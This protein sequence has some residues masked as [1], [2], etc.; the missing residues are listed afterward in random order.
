MVVFVISEEGKP[1]MPTRRFGKVRRLL[2]KGLAKVV[3]HRPFTIQLLYKTTHYTQSVKVGFDTGTTMGFAVVVDN[4]QGGKVVEKGEIRFRRDISK[5]LLQRREYR[6]FRRYRKTPYRKPRFLNRRRPEGWLAPSVRARF[7]HTLRWIERLTKFLPDPEVIV[8]IARFDT[9]NL[10]NPDV[11]GEEYQKGNLYGYANVLEY[12]L[13]RENGKCQLCGKGYGGNGNGW[14]IHHIIPRSKGGTDRPDNLAL[15]HR[16]CHEKIHRNPKLMAKLKKP[17]LYKE[18]AYLNSFRLQLIEELKALLR[19]KVKF[20][21][22]YL[23]KIHRNKI[24]LTKTHAND[25]VAMTGFTNPKD[26]NTIT[27]IRQVRKKKRSLH[28]ATP[29]KGRT[30]PNTEAKRNSKNTKQV[31]TKD[32]KLW[33]LWDKVKIDGQVGFISGFTSGSYAYIQDISDNYIRLA[34]KNYKQVPLKQTILIRRNN[35]WV[36]RVMVV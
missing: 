27:I 20:T 12:L 25:A 9:Q 13:T 32:G 21:Y 3:C 35:N 2:K 7:E 22:G 31:R 11:E 1:L 33:C 30:K 10:Q 29:R 4:R 6:R 8:E 17:K 28:E 34:G 14:Q 5:L 18:P 15:L 23:T 24:G 26:I 36:E 16:K 19:D